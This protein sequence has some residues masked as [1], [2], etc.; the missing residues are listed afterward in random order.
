MII[1]IDFDGTA[2]T[3]EYPLVGKDIGAQKV[4]KKTNR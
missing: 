3:H 4:L 2:T 1:N